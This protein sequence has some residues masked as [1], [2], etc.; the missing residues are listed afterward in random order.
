MDATVGSPTLGQ[1]V[2]VGTEQNQLT[3]IWQSQF[4]IP[5]PQQ[6][7]T[8]AKSSGDSFRPTEVI[9]DRSPTG[10][11]TDASN[12]QLFAGPNGL[13]YFTADNGANGS[14]VQALGPTTRI[15]N[16]GRSTQTPMSRRSSRI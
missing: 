1:I 6:D 4:D 8:Y 14:K 15:S 11:R 12:R 5:D 7:F 13:I 9:Q 3:N 2:Q 10:F 16:R